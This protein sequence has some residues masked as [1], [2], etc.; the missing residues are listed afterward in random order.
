MAKLPPEDLSKELKN[1][2]LDTDDL[3]MQRSLGL[4]WDLDTDSFTFRV[5]LKETP[6]TRRGVL[7]TVSSLYDPLGL[8][9]PVTIQGKL[10]LRN[11]ISGTVDWDEPL[12][13]NHKAL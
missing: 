10:I 13:E 12:S 1:L 8:I 9:A 7:S 2:D 11:L 5:S 3:P 4:N 6:F